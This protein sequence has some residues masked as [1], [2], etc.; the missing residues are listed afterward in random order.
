MTGLTVGQQGHDLCAVDAFCRNPL[1][2]GPCK[3]WKNT[4]GKVAPGAL[5]V[6]EDERKRK[7]AVRRAAKA[8]KVAAPP[9]TPPVIPPTESP[10]GHKPGRWA[11]EG[12]RQ[13]GWQGAHDQV[14][15][16]YLPP[17][18]TP[19]M[20]AKLARET[21]DKAFPES[22]KKFRNGNVTV[23]FRA[24]VPD[25]Q[26]RI[27]L[28]TVDKLQATNPRPN[29]SIDV[30][31][32]DYDAT[33]FAF[34]GQESLI[35]N[36]AQL[37]STPWAVSDGWASPSASRMSQIEYVMTHEWGHLISH[38]TGIDGHATEGEGVSQYGHTNADEAYAE[39]FAEY[40]HA[41]G[42]PGFSNTAA[43]EA[44]KRYG[45]VNAQGETP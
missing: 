40:F 7:V 34:P 24:D 17:F 9:V 21:A 11:P 32:M 35:M 30:G 45:W 1:H 33:A 25:D 36:S 38:D 15:N 31:P 8:A 16:S 3:G 41:S 43:S 22:W 26:V 28:A 12:N 42:Q 5:K 20:R 19:E 4:L 2:P 39:L 37:T 13:E 23:E 18:Y 14:M 27:A 29:A 10:S 6:I 44:A